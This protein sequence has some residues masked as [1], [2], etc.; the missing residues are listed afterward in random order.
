LRPSASWMRLTSIRSRSSVS[1]FLERVGPYHAGGVVG[2]NEIAQTRTFVGGSVGDQPAADQAMAAIGADVVLVAAGA[3]IG[4]SRMPAAATRAAV[5]PA[6]SRAA[7]S[8]H[9]ASGTRRHAIS[10][11]STIGRIA[12]SG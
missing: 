6:G 4:L 7:R 3:P 12:L 2:V 10:A 1:F 9:R 11:A 8:R 5:A